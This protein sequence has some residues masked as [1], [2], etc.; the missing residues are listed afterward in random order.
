MIFFSL[1]IKA[2]S[3]HIFFL[4]MEEI[5]FQTGGEKIWIDPDICFCIEK[6]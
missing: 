3:I 2:G 4:L 1:K 5:Y 6:K